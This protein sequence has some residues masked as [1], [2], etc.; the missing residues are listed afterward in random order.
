MPAA[1]RPKSKPCPGP[2]QTWPLTPTGHCPPP[3][4]RKPH[5]SP[6][7]AW[8]TDLS[9]VH[10]NV[11]SLAAQ[12]TPHHMAGPTS[13][14]TTPLS[15]SLPHFL[16]QGLVC[17]QAPC[18]PA[19]WSSQPADSTETTWAPNPSSA[20]LVPPT[21]RSSPEW[22]HRVADKSPPPSWPALLCFPFL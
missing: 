21:A 8:A 6:P 14:P 22:S 10:S 20:Q 17:P 16:P 18:R 12:A 1:L 3:L 2:Q 19:G 11:T 5:H 9:R 7:P 4:S 15:R 13:F